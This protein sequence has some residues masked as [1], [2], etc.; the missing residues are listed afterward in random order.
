MKEDRNDQKAST[1]V[2]ELN[3]RNFM[4]GLLLVTG[5]TVLLNVSAVTALADGNQ[6][7]G[8]K[9]SIIEETGTYDCQGKNVTYY[10]ARPAQGNIFPTVFLVHEIFGWTENARY[11]AQQLAA[12]GNLVFLPHV[13]PAVKPNTS[14]EELVLPTEMDKLAEGFAFLLKR[15]DVDLSNVR[16]VGRCWD[17]VGGDSRQS[18]TLNAAGVSINFEVNLYESDFPFRRMYQIS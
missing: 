16:G 14:Y 3:R 13:L 18:Y 6:G 17:K 10:V 12:K 1:S 5:A 2:G 15:P 9:V 11:L 4:Q 8:G 7:S